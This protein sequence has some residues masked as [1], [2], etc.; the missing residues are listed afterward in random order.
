[1]VN[2]QKHRLLVA[3]ACSIR[4]GAS[5]RIKITNGPVYDLKEVQQL[6]KVHG[7]RVINNDAHRD[8][9][10]FYPELTDD[11][12]GKFIL[13]LIENDHLESERCRTSG[14]QRIDCDA[15]TM[16]WNRNRCCRWEYAAKL[17]VK[18][19]FSHQDS[20]CLVLSIHPSQW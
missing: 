7:L 8:Q 20:R 9:Q 15:Y 12:L 5:G 18:F 17:Y 19:G 4:I 11:E 13:A 10:N 3:G 16:K 1:M 14:G 6:L 2:N